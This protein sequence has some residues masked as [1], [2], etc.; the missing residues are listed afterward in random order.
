M[1]IKSKT[2]IKN[3]S[4]ALLFSLSLLL[5]GNLQPTSAQNLDT[6]SNYFVHVAITPSDIEEG[7]KTHPIGYVYVVNKNGVSITSDFDVD[8]ELTSDN[9]T[10]ASVP[11]KI[12]FP[13]NASFAKFDITAGENGKTT[14][15]AK[16][17]EK[18]GFTDINVGTDDVF[19]PDDVQLELN[20]PTDQMHVNS[21]M[22]FSVFLKSEGIVLRAPYDIDVVLDYEKS[23]AVPNDDVLTIKSGEY[24]AWGTLSTGEKTGNSFIR[25]IQTDAQLD[26]A[27][28]LEI[29]STLPAA[30]NINIYPYL[31]PAEIDRNLDIF[32]SV[33]DSNGDPTVA[34]RD[35]PLK[36][37]S[38]NQ[39]FIGEEID[40]A[41]EELNMVIKKGSFGYHF[42]LNVDLIGLVSNDLLIGVSS[43][44]YGTS[45][46]KFQTVGESISVEDKRMS[47]NSLITGDRIVDSS[48]NKVVQI[49]GPLRI[50][51]NSSAIFAYQMA[52]E[53]DDDNDNPDKDPDFEEVDIDKVIEAQEDE[54]EERREGQN[55]QDIGGTG[56]VEQDAPSQ[57]SSSN[58]DDDLDVLIFGIDN[59]EEGNNYPIQANE[60][61]RATGLIQLLDVIS[62][63]NSLA[64]VTDAGN[65][66]PSYSYGI[67]TVNTGQKSGEF[68][69]SANIKGI[70]SGSFL[71]EVVNTLEQK[72]I[73]A[74]SPT[75]EKSILINRD[76]SFD[77]FLVALDG[78]DRPKVLDYDKKFLV[79]PTNG[80][81]DLKEGTTFTLTTLQSESF[82]L[83]N[84]GSVVIKAESIGQQNEE[85]LESTTVFNTQ[86]SS[87]INVLFPI[88]NL[89]IEKEEHVGV[90]Q[91]TDLQGHPIE[92]FSDMKVK[93][94]ST[95]ESILTINEDSV[96][97]KGESYVEF[98]IDVMQKIGTVNVSAATRGVVPS[99]TE[100][101]TSTSAS[102]LSVF[103][104]GLIEP[105][106]VNEEIQV[107]IFVDDD[108]ADSVAGATVKINPDTNATTSVDL[109]RTDSDGSATFGLTALNGP[110]ITI[111]FEATA[112]G[113]KD[114]RK[115]LDIVVDTPPGGTS[116]AE[117]NLPTELV[118]VIIGGIVV[119]IIVV[120]LFLKKSKE[121]ME[122]EEEPWE[123]DDI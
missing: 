10:I 47:D 73:V 54:E 116:V 64:T 66:R 115:S 38:N 72:R 82:N 106:P 30:L 57:S 84:G 114:G 102:S 62:G 28:S 121:P 6:L 94:S 77:L 29:T 9:P 123:D 4:L 18:I 110:E 22:P 21:E 5:G 43:A 12:T 44:G 88:D 13:A 58:D 14:I 36:F 23:L 53:E 104:S 107:K 103:T 95:N 99:G 96:I 49:F 118:Y 81:V 52:I 32:V 78:V 42:R 93:I 70:G 108:F 41:M 86:L 26:T 55:S 112:D 1:K 2:K 39:D 89:D 109:V 31:I 59:L 79:T 113:Y 90:V 8:V 20:I 117:L 40:D 27:K 76:G 69:I 17:N 105:I 80:I 48:D 85:A 91:L 111:N 87:K 74:F 97:K 16:I 24:Y 7:S 3:Y 33:I 60:D 119:V 122:D 65:I 67:A 45:I 92:T 83:K 98:P 120:V 100:I 35:I 37:F 46:D 71:S 61:Y 15:T 68:L 50:P 19:L 56:D 11:E 51:S 34:N 25:A 75:G 63:D 101:N